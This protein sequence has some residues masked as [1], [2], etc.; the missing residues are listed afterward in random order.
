MSK[1]DKVIDKCCTYLKSGGGFCMSTVVTFKEI[2]F[3]SARRYKSMKYSWQ[4]RHAPF[5]RPSI[6][7]ACKNK[8]IRIRK[9]KNVKKKINNI[10]I[11]IKKTREP[12]WTLK[13]N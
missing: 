13:I 12:I 11:K 9:F 10:Y 2:V 6:V 3:N 7:D 8:L 4:N 1:V 5:L